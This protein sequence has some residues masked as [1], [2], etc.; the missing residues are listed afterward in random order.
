MTT[1]IH[2]R[3]SKTHTKFELPIQTNPTHP[4]QHT[5]HKTRTYTTTMSSKISANR[6]LEELTGDNE[7]DITAHTDVKGENCVAWFFANKQLKM[8]IKIEAL[9][10][11]VQD[12]EDERDDKDEEIEKLKEEL[13]EA[14]EMRY[15]GEEMEKMVKVMEHIDEHP[16]Y[17]ETIDDLMSDYEDDI[18]KLKEQIE[19][20]NTHDTTCMCDV[21]EKNDKLK[22]ENLELRL[23][24]RRN[25]DEIDRL[26]EILG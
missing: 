9:E 2:P 10:D 3:Q 8:E 15:T 4:T 1:T 13:N 12:L 26:R 17:K 7:F 25:Q 21:C 23:W 24:V 5:T 6:R 19:E 22:E 14:P 18:K 11:E 16:D 20:N